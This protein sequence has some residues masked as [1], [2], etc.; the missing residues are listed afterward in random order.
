MKKVKLRN[1]GGSYYFPIPKLWAKSHGLNIKMIMCGKNI[2]ICP[3]DKSDKGL[4]REIIT[5]SP[6]KYVV[7]LPIEW[8]HSYNVKSVFFKCDSNGNIL[9]TPILKENQTTSG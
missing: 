4:E 2:I 1:M 5:P 9:I 3:H 6:E 8:V 7:A